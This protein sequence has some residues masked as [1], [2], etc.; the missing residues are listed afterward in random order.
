[1]SEHASPS[2]R[3]T[4]WVVA[5]ISGAAALFFLSDSKPVIQPGA[6]VRTTFEPSARAIAV[7][8]QANVVV[9]DP[10]RHYDHAVKLGHVEVPEPVVE[11]AGPLKPEGAANAVKTTHTGFSVCAECHADK[12][13]TAQH[14]SHFHTS[15]R[16]AEKHLAE[17]FSG[18]AAE[19]TTR[20][21]G[22][23]FRMYEEDGRRYQ[24]VLWEG[25]EVH[26]APMEVVFGSGKLGFSYGY[27]HGESLL[28]LPVSY[29][30]AKDKWVNSPGYPDGTALYTRPIIS[31]CLTCHATTSLPLEDTLQNFKFRDRN[32]TFGVT[33]ERCHG[34]GRRHVEHHRAHPE[35]KTARHIRDPRKLDQS[36]LNQLC[37]ECHGGMGNATDSKPGVHSNNQS[38]RLQKSR[39]FT[40]S[41]GMRCTDCHNP[42]QFERGKTELFSQRCQKCHE[43]EDCGDFK[44]ARRTHFAANCPTCHMEK[45]PLTDIAIETTEGIVFPDLIDH[46]IR[47]IE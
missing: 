12:V 27:W 5:A 17:L 37:A 35:D 16:I 6:P 23:T 45:Q 31:D 2:G 34:A 3:W 11:K 36:E 25:E 14:T 29:L 20:Q 43:V 21:P 15:D 38:Q 40:E 10:A 46:Y 28:Q 22:L 19:L 47:V 26:R 1:M 13:E 33:C 41:G 30:A 9:M 24:A 32:V 7:A 44:P 4:P 42:H 18:P 39:C 8:T